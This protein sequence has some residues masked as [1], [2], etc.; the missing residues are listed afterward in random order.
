MHVGIAFLWWR[1]KRSRHSRRM[2]IRNY[3]YLV[4]SPWLGNC[5]A[6]SH[7]LNQGILIVYQTLRNTLQCNPNRNTT[8]LYHENTFDNLRRHNYGHLFRPDCVNACLLHSICESYTVYNVTP[9]SSVI[10]NNWLMMH[11]AIYEKTNPLIY[12]INSSWWYKVIAMGQCK[13]DATPWLTHW[14]YV[15]LAVTHRYMVK[16]GTHNIHHI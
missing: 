14:S 8:I 16:Q 15:F 1:G 11:F 4:R 3:T 10:S 6:L 7:C 2:R 12:K 13:K 9:A 5:S